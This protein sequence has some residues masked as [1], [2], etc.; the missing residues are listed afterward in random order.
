MGDAADVVDAAIAEMLATA[1]DDP[2]DQRG[3]VGKVVQPAVEPMHA[4][5]CVDARSLVVVE[6]GLQHDPVDA[7]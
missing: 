7:R 4:R 5:M 3:R 1:P 6:C 2:I